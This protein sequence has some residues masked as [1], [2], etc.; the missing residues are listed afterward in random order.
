MPHADER[1]HL[2]VELKRPS[3]KLNSEA[4]S[5]IKSYAFAVADD[6]R[7]KHTKTTWTF[8]AL[9]NE[10]DKEVGREAAQRGRE[11]GILHEDADRRLTIWVKTWGQ[12]IE[13]CRGRMA[14]FQKE[15][16]YRADRDSGLEYLRATHAKYLPDTAKRPPGGR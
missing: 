1:E 6:E 7:F 9:S 5:Q 15:L 10:I 3:E 11:A 13:E 4:A 14:F 12:I 2:V 16:Q 8:W